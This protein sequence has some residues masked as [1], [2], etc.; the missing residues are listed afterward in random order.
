MKKKLIILATLAS[1]AL[2]L[3][4]CQSDGTESAPSVTP[5]PE[6]TSYTVIDSQ[7][8]EINFETT[9][10]TVV[11]LAPNVTE[12]IFAL[13][14]EEKLIARTDW[15]NYPEDVF[16]Y[17]SV[18][19]IDQPDVEAIIALDPDVVILSE[20]TMQELALQVKDAGIPIVV[21][22]EEG[23]FAGAYR[24]IEIVGMVLGA[25]EK[26][27]EVIDGMKEQIDAVSA[28]VAGAEKKTV[29][30]VMGYGEYGD[31]TAGKGTF[32]SEMIAAA[33][34]INVADDTDGWA[35]SVEKLVEHDPD[36]LLLSVWAPSE[37][38]KT[39]TGYKDLASVKEDK[40]FTLDDDS[41]QRLGPR[42]GEAFEKMAK[43]IHPELFE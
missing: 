8:T 27:A 41:L 15:C 39:A 5:T 34:G 11:S 17:T 35:Y 38:L 31:F 29:Y 26:A 37:G 20:I 1:L 33:G 14:V 36:L 32:I 28:K 10:K 42:L 43:A 16:N 24:C 25:D 13:G 30:Y 23:S 6:D 9:P 4:G 7:G 19:N 3:A 40:M 18:G 2:V 12:I 22:D 21:V